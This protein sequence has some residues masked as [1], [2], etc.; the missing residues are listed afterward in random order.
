[1]LKTLHI[2]IFLVLL[3]GISFI[4]AQEITIA[5]EKDTLE[6][7]DNDPVYTLLVAASQGDSVRVQK[8]LKAGVKVDT[9]TYE[10]IPA[11]MYAVRNGYSGTAKMLVENGAMI[12]KKTYDGNTALLIAV[13]N[14]N[15]PLTEYLIRKGADIN[16]GDNR[17][18]TPLMYAAGIDSFALADMLL[19]YGADVSKADSN[20]TTALMIASVTGNFDM[21]Y[22]IL[23]SG[24]PVNYRDKKGFVPLH[25]ATFY[26][27]WS[28][29]E[30]LLDFGADLAVPD[31]NG[32]SPLSV[33]VVAN[34][35]DATQ[36]LAFAG[37]DINQKISFSQNP[38]T[39]AVENRNDSIVSFLRDNKAH[40]NYWPGFYKFGLGTEFAG[41]TDD[42]FWNFYFLGS[43][44]KYKLN[45]RAGGGFRPSPTRVLENDDKAYAYQY[46]EHRGNLF[47]SLDKSIF[48]FHGWHGLRAGIYGG[49]KG[50]YT[51]GNYRGSDEKPDS[52]FL[53]V[54][55]IGTTLERN[56]FRITLGYEYL[57]LNLYKINP[58]RISISVGLRWNRKKNNFKPNFINWF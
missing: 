37:A 44:R 3:P 56:F 16:L 6:L 26:G 38:L 19:Y 32:Y 22:A 39:I 28:I 35:L 31:V 48:L 11:L 20:G 13:Q 27:Y 4:S 7:L 17:G 55:G 49:L 34:D 23:E 2:I 53:L 36:I 1:M 52:R 45:L 29:M 50:V 12:N 40:Y 33:A 42:I 47:L 57:N 54:P 14:G 46:W 15:L 21:V 9:T 51:F 30:L 41:N 58:N 18:V 8:L 25:A 10:G 5:P 43:E 24:A